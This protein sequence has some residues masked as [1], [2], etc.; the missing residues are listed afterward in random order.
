[1]SKSIFAL[2]EPPDSVAF[3]A[4]QASVL[5]AL[6]AGEK[7]VSVDLDRISSLDSAAMRRL[8]VLLRRA[9]ERG[10]EIGLVTGRADILRSLR[11]TALD[12]VFN[13]A[14]PPPAVAA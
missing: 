5:A 2:G 1:M 12:K 4:L 13:V 3:E 14:A 7:I 10:G 9:R 11:V 8:I 6:D